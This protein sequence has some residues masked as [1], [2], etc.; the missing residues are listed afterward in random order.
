MTYFVLSCSEDGVQ[1]RDFSK[2]A[3]EKYLKAE[4]EDEQ[5]HT[6][7]NDIPA[8]DKGSWHAPENSLLIIKGEIVMPTQKQ[9][10]MKY[11]VD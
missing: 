7:L 3:L 11:E 2:A 6:F 9:V 4:L 8:Q 1:I 5:E 10:V